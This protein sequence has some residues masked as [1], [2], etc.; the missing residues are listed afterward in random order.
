M[1]GLVVINDQKARV[2]VYYWRGRREMSMKKANTVRDGGSAVG[3]LERN[4]F[5]FNTQNSLNWKI[6]KTMYKG[7]TMSL[8]IYIPE[9]KCHKD[10]R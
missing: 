9:F 2:A 4:Q 8:I 10:V 5:R 6:F 1:F 7:Q 3:R